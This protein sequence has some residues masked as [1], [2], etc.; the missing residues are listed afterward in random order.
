MKTS[1]KGSTYLARNII[2]APTQMTTAT[3]GRRLAT[4]TVDRISELSTFIVVLF[5]PR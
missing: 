3:S 4:S 5:L 1:R 2:M